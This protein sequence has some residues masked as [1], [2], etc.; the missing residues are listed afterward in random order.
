MLTYKK[1]TLKPVYCR[2]YTILYCFTPQYFVDKSWGFKAFLIFI[3]VICSIVL[4]LLINT[5]TKT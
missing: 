4:I 5:T 1:N 3:E 2:F